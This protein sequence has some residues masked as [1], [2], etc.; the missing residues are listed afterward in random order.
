MD[1]DFTPEYPFG[2]G[3]SY[4]KFEY[5]DL[6]TSTMTAGRRIISAQVANT[7]PRDADEIVQFYVHQET[8]SVA[9]PVRELKGF[10]RIHLKPGER[11]TVTFTLSRDDLAFYNQQLH[12]VTEPGKIHVWIA[13]DSTG[14]VEGQFTLE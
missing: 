2:F 12:R 3:L 5:S 14:G 9:R 8:A 6:R 7:G 13:P 4:T 10:R 11:A 1:V